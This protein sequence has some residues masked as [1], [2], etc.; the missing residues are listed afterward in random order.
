MGRFGS[1]ALGMLIRLLAASGSQQLVSGP[2]HVEYEVFW[3]E[4]ISYP[5]RS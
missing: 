3:A 5:N 4:M 1:L 2:N